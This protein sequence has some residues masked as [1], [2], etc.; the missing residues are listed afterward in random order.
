MSF[1]EFLAALQICIDENDGEHAP[2]AKHELILDD[3]GSFD[4]KA[5]IPDFFGYKMRI[6]FDDCE[7]GK[8]IYVYLSTRTNKNIDRRSFR[9]SGYSEDGAQKVFDFMMEIVE[10]AQHNVSADYKKY[11]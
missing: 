7:Y 5:H 4:G 9:L 2:V 6:Y 11:L 3:A 1:D 8:V 10:E